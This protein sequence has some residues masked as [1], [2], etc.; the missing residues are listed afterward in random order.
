MDIATLEAE[1][2]RRLPTTR[3]SAAIGPTWVSGERG[4]RL[5]GLVSDESHANDHMGTV[6]G[7]VLMTFADIALGVCA[8]DTLEQPWMATAQLQ[9]QFVAAAPVGSFV[10]CSPELVRKTSQLIFVRGLFQA[11]ERTVGSADGI[12]KVF[13]TER[14]DRLKAG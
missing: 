10:T 9:F 8:G 13:D 4:S 11:D 12:F 14:I 2:W 6:H 1:G 3:F 5:V 7:G